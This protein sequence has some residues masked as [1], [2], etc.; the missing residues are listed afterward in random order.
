MQSDTSSESSVHKRIV[1]LACLKKT[2]KRRL[3][4]IHIPKTGGTTL[5]RAFANSKLFHN[6]EHSFPKMGEEVVGR[7]K[8]SGHRKTWP[9][10]KCMGLR[11]SDF[12]IAI[13]RNPFDWLKSYYF[14]IGSGSFGF[15]KHRG[16][17][18]SVDYHN[19]SS[20][21]EFV[22]SYCNKDDLWHVPALKQNPWAQIVTEDG[23]FLTDITLFNEHLTE[24]IYII[25][26]YL[27]A[28]LS[29]NNFRENMGQAGSDYRKY[30]TTEMID[31]VNLKFKRILQITNYEFEQ[32]SPKSN[33][34]SLCHLG[35]YRKGE[36]F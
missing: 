34:H 14:H 36:I 23:H 30:F 29:N 2:T 19:F 17:Q 9:S 5:N 13:I 6:G 25:A 24:S 16:W 20:F 21:S 10:H 18:G 22:L 8:I 1:S 11:N 28:T 15:R 35:L 7:V 4:H 3:F 31:A 33:P 26:D 27:G 12:T 32:P